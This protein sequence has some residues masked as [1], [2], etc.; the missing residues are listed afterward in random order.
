MCGEK[1]SLSKLQSSIWEK[2]SKDETSYSFADLDESVLQ[3][4]LD[5]DLNN[6]SSNNNYTVK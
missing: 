4:L 5:K 1:L 6:E 2:M 3:S